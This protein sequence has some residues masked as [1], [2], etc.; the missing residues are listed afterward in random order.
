[1]SGV[2]CSNKVLLAALTLVTLS[3]TGCG[4]EKLPLEYGKYNLPDNYNIESMDVQ[5]E[6]PLFA[7]D[8]CAV[9]DNITDT[10]SIDPSS[11]YGAGVFDVNTK[12]TL[13]A[14]N[15]NER[16]NPASLTKIMTALVVIENCNL[17]DVVTVPD[18]SIG[19]EGVQTFGLKEGDK[20]TVKNL[21]YISLVYSGNDA[22]LCLAKYVAGSEAAFA[23]MMNAKAASLGAS[24]SHFINPH[25]LTSSEHY[26]TAYDLYLIFNA[27]CK[28]QEFLDIISTDKYTV[29]YTTA[30]GEAKDKEI[31]TTNKFLTG[32]YTMPGSVQVQ[33]GKTGSTAAAGKCIILYDVDGNGNPYISVVM[34]ASS[35]ENLY[36][37]MI[38][39]CN[40]TIR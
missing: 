20:I 18:V 13:Y 27:A 31:S 9:K 11:L 29:S 21:L 34:G 28:H 38:K 26:T 30:E 24:N 35:E 32:G 8:I 15:V 2:R 33:G 1:M 16:V 17:D 23:E 14:Y 5:S 4:K 25:G 36:N 39:L 37:T 22:S 6:V 40:D 12:K 19:E 10:S 3:L 7:S